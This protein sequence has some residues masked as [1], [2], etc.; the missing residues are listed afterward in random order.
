MRRASLL[1]AT[2]VLAVVIGGGVALAATIQCTGG[3]CNG[4]P[5]NDS[6]FGTPRHDAI[7]AHQGSDHVVGYAGNDN[8][9]GQ[10]G[11]DRVFGG[12]GNDWAK[13]GN[14]NDEVKG[15]PGQDTL[16]GGAGHDVIR[17]VDGQ[18]DLIICGPGSRDHVFYDRNLDEFRNC[19]FEHAR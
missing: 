2:M 18:R 6:M 5:R 11:P 8:L 16:T 17:A 1:L 3:T 4:T 10:D 14:Q 7:F 13:G 19:E 9:N 12:P 15:G